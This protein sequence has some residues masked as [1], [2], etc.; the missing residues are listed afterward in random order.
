MVAIS[1][2]PAFEH[3]ATNPIN[4]RVFWFDVVLSSED[5]RIGPVSHQLMRHSGPAL[6]I[7]FDESSLMGGV[8]EEVR[9]TAGLALKVFSPIRPGSQ[10]GKKE[11]T[12]AK[13]ALT[14]VLGYRN[15]EIRSK[16]SQKP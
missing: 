11:Q 15:C 8:H 10:L 14:V 7:L 3:Y 9:V 6:Q 4:P 13:F 5:N 16:C 1:S 2:K 12:T